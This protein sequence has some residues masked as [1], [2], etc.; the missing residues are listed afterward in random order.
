[1]G[2]VFGFPRPQK[3]LTDEEVRYPVYRFLANTSGH[4]LGR[5]TRTRSGGT[6]TFWFFLWMVC[7]SILIYQAS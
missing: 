7:A 6:R 5:I 2:E 1:M 4:G 3:E